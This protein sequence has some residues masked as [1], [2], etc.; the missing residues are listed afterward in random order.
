MNTPQNTHKQDH[1]KIGRYQS[2]ME[3]GKLKLYY[4]EFGNPNGI[5]CTMNAQEAKGLLEMLS[6]HSDDINQA[7][8]T[9]EKEKANY[10]RIG[11]A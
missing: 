3:D 9:D 10:Q 2:W 1:M 11:R 6:N 4:H 7:L 8:Y 5:Y